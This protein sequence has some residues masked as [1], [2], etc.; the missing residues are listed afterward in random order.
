MLMS[1]T[2][3][4]E[5]EQATKRHQKGEVAARTASFEIPS[6]PYRFMIVKDP[7]FFFPFFVGSCFSQQT[8]TV[9]TWKSLAL[10]CTFT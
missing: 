4:R 1:K 7:D 3:E 8:H 10:F 2:H 6:V 5:G 9:L